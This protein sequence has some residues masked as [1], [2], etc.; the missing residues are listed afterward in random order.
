MHT[1]FG[2]VAPPGE[3]STSLHYLCQQLK[4]ATSTTEMPL[5]YYISSPLTKASVPAEEPCSMMLQPSLSLL[6]W[7][8]FGD[9][10]FFLH[11]TYL[12]EL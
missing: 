9:P 12:L 7:C 5:L 8:P 4:A 2:V 10:V 6:A 11:Q 3:N 1:Y